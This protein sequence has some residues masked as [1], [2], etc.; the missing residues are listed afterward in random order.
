MLKILH[1]HR[2]FILDGHRLALLPTMSA[3]TRKR[4]AFNSQAA[5]EPIAI[6]RPANAS[7][8]EKRR[9]ERDGRKGNKK[10][11]KGGKGK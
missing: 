9:Q 5:T 3:P 6:P 8:N 4:L 11:G 1:G 2:L 10:K 7:A